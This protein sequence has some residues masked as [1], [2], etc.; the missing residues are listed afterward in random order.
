MQVTISQDGE[1]VWEIRLRLTEPLRVIATTC[2]TWLLLLPLSVLI[3]SGMLCPEHTI[4][5]HQENEKEFVLM[6]DI[7]LTHNHDTLMILCQ[8]T[9]ALTYTRTSSRVQEAHS[10]LTQVKQSLASLSPKA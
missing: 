9:Y 7:A 3:L 2:T 6:V 10:I 8:S 5:P 4:T 1:G